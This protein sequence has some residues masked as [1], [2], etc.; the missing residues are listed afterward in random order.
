MD[1][2]GEL[3]Y[4]CTRPHSSSSLSSSLHGNTELASAS[5]KPLVSGPALQRCINPLCQATFDV[6]QVK[7][8][9]IV[10]ATCWM[11]I[12]NGPKS[13]CH[14]DLAILRSSGVAL[15]PL[16]FLGVWRFHELLPFV[17][18]EQVVTVGEVRHSCKKPTK[19]PST[20][21]STRGTNYRAVSSV[22]DCSC[23]TKA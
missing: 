3:G 7:R 12:T 14:R 6:S 11:S 5:T 10:A 22:A 23:N 4:N 18:P 2:G 19:S 17:K 8:P 15:E 1:L 21:A 9:A 20:S 13:L 16:R